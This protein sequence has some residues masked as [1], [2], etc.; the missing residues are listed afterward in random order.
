MDY[1]LSE[2]QISEYI[3]EFLK[4][5]PFNKCVFKDNRFTKNLSPYCGELTGSV[6][7]IDKDY[8]TNAVK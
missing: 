5:C 6:V 3:E 4:D 2:N 8:I 1:L 7:G